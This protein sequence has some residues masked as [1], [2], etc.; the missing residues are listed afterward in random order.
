MVNELKKHIVAL[1]KYNQCHPEMDKVL[2]AIK[3]QLDKIDTVFLKL[4]GS[5]LSRKM[6]LM[7]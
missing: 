7:N 2:Q 4:M 6:L 1:E 5:P 3:S